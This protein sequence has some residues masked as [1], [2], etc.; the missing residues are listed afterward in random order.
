MQSLNP[1]EKQTGFGRSKPFGRIHLVP[2]LC[3]NGVKLREEESRT[4]SLGH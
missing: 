4:E 2:T 1:A 3:V